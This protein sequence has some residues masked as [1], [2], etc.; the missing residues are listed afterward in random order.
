M[1]TLISRAGTAEPVIEQRPVPSAGHDELVVAVR[2]AAVNPADRMVFDDAVRDAFGLPAQIGLGWDI[3]GVVHEVGD[4]VDGVAVGDRVAALEDDLTH[5][6]RAHA[7]YVAVPALNAAPIPDDLGFEQAASLPL[8]ALT[9]AQAL[10]LLGEPAG[11]SL[12]VT[13]AAGAVGGFAIALAHA[14]GWDVTGLA[15]V[16][17][18]EFVTSTGAG[19]ITQLPSEPTYDA[20]LNTVWPPEDA[21]ESVRD[22]G[23][24]VTP[25]LPPP[26][27]PPRRIEVHAVQVHADGS[28]LG[29]L[30]RLG[31]TGQLQPRIAGTAALAEFSSAYAQLGVSGQRGRWLLIP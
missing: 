30:L 19:L 8:N 18:E 9:A 4:G 3:A 7:E 24:L 6:T 25:V 13:G 17:D 23:A 26:A 29:E 31:A 22:G 21:L 14:A 28:R 15:R 1:K 16:A 2:A 5:A 20:V 10:E 12:L 27:N 11:R